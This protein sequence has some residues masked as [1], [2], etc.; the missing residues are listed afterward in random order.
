MSGIPNGRA[1]QG[2][3]L[4][5]SYGYVLV[6]GLGTCNLARKAV[7]SK[8]PRSN[9]H[10]LRNWGVSNHRP[11]PTGQSV[12]HY[13]DSKC[14]RH[15]QYVLNRWQL[16]FIARRCEECNRERTLVSRMGL[17]ALIALFIEYGLR[18]CCGSKASEAK[19]LGRFSYARIDSLPKSI[20][21]NRQP[22]QFCQ[23]DGPLVCAGW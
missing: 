15:S 14:N 8:E 17:G 11:I 1:F 9:R 23:R 19:L 6:S 10:F 22:I 3:Q 7:L 13:P 5:G 12:V 20:E 21:I 16:L 4:I 18:L 2:I